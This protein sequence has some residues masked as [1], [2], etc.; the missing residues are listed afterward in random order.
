[1]GE[2]LVENQARQRHFPVQVLQTP[3]PPPQA[4]SQPNWTQAGDT[5][6]ASAD[7]LNKAPEA[8]RAAAAQKTSFFIFI[9]ISF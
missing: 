1:M 7:L 4:D 2:T 8:R 5:I 6:Q 3:S 9:A